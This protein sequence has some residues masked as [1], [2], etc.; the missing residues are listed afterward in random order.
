MF[1]F[2]VFEIGEDSTPWCVVIGL[3]VILVCAK[4]FLRKGRGGNTKD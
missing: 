1:A 3:F 2:F 4:L